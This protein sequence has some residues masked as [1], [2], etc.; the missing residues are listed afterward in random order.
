MEWVE[1][2][3][4]Y[5]RLRRTLELM[6]PE[7]NPMID[8]NIVPIHPTDQYGF[9]SEL[10]TGTELLQQVQ[11][12]AERNGRVCFYCESSLFEQDWPLIPH[13][14]AGGSTIRKSAEGWEV[15][16]PATVTLDWVGLSPLVDGKPWPCY[17]DDGIILPGGTHQLSFTPIVVDS[18]LISP[19]LIAISDELVGSV[20]TLQGIDVLYV[21]P[22]RCLLTF[23]SPPKN[24][25]LDDSPTNLPVL[26]RKGR[27]IVIAPSGKHKLSVQAR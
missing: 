12:A 19:R 18:K 17:G 3:A 7:R 1:P 26:T 25:L 20:R 11:S 24:L 8:I 5:S 4:R 21:S 10:A 13:A 23:D 15:N 2:P 9:P 22:A 16:A 27:F 14:M 6:M